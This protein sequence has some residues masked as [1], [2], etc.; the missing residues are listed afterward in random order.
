[1]LKICATCA[2]A[3]TAGPDPTTATTHECRRQCPAIEPAT[4]VG[5]WPR[6][7]SSDW[8]GEWAAER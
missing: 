3:R 7:V 2:L 4:G 8:C 5:V 6:V 1:M